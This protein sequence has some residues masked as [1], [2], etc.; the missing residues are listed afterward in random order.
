MRTALPPFDN[1]TGLGLSFGEFT[2]SGSGRQILIP[3]TRCGA[4][5]RFHAW[6]DEI[7]DPERERHKRP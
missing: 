6:V 4:V 2:D 1:G 5:T 7:S 3:S